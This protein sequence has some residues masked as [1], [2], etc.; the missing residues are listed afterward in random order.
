VWKI[1]VFLSGFLPALFVLTGA[2]MWWIKRVRRESPV[3]TED[4]A[5]DQI[6]T[7]R[8]AGE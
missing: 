5:F 1:L 8:R 2:S 7:A 4:L 6:D 3:A